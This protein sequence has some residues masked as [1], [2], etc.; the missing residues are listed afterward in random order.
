MTAGAGGRL[1]PDDFALDAALV[2]RLLAEQFPRLAGLA[3]TEVASTGTVNRLFRL[4]PDLCV[5]L[6]RGPGRDASLARE[7][8]WLPRLAEA[9]SLAVPRPVGAGR[10]GAGYPS[11]WALYRW[12]DGEVFRRGDVGD[13]VVADQL[14]GLVAELRAVDA[15]GAPATGRRP[16]AELDR[17]TRFCAAALAPEADPARVEA[18]W[19]RALE[20][21]VFTGTGCLRHGDLLPPN[22]LVTG[23][24][25]SAV[26]DWG[27]VGPGDPAAD[28][29]P[30]WSV[31]GPAG[32]A[33]F[34]RATGADEGTWARA[35]GYALH[36]AVLI[37]PYYRTTNPAF[38]A[39]AAETVAQVLAD[40]D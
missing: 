13:K 29:V 20:A 10:P 31:L 23:G 6:P 40:R 5:R 34:R 15:G 2:R 4:G 24:R 26:L 1:H 39:L 18:A 36:Q 9:V 30:A 11:A 19:S 12:L 21:P 14:A 38:S 25:I 3:L 27:D 35:R 37:I 22:L 7:L 33:A 16:L 32:R 8:D 28:L 17:A